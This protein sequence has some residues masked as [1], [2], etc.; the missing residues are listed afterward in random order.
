MHPDDRPPIDVLIGCTAAG[1]TAVALEL[2]RRIDAEIVSVDSMLIYRGMD[3]GTGKPTA[4][5]REQVPHHLIDVREPHEPFSVAE[6][7]ELADA[8]IAEIRRRGRAVLAVGGTALYLKALLYGLFAGPSRDPALRQHIREQAKR[9]GTAALHAQLARLDPDSARRI[10]PNDLR[11]I[12]RAL[13][14][15]HVTGRPISEHQQQ[16]EA[17]RTR[18][19]VRMFGLARQREDLHQR[20]NRRVVQMIQA[21]WVEELRELLSQAQPMSQQARQA[22]GYGILAEHLA[23]Q[24]SLDEAVERV[25]IAT[26]QFA[27]AQ[28]TWFR[29]FDPVTWINVGPDES[30]GSVVERIL[31]HGHTQGDAR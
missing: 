30:P 16:W 25:K 28:R 10:H 26:R 20:I 12:E 31:V 5:Q 6:Y 13:E 29:R 11:R 14:V 4:A 23:G 7:L 21:G 2:A 19:R 9:D 3:I 18:Y 15:Y 1:K 27:K 8:A 22:L 24:I 17:R